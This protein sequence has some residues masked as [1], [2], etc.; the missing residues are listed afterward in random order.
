MFFLKKI[1]SFS[2]YTEIIFRR[3]YYFLKDVGIVSTK[4]RVVKKCDDKKLDFLVLKK[5]I[6]SLGIKEGDILIV[7][8]SY[9]QLSKFEVNP[10]GIINFLRELIGDEGTL[11]FPAFYIKKEDPDK[12]EI[13]IDLNKKVCSTGMLPAVFLRMKGVLRSPFPEN[14]LAAQGPRAEAMFEQ[15]LDTDLA[16]G[17]GSAWHF[18]A[19]NDA[20]ILLLGTE[21]AKTLTMVHV[22]EDVLDD[23]WP[24]MDWYEKKFFNLNYPDDTKQKVV[25]VRRQYWSRFMA[26]E[27]RTRW[28]KSNNLVSENI[29][30]GV[31]VAYVH[32]SK[33]L[34]ETL[35]NNMNSRKVY[36][37]R[38][39]TKYWRHRN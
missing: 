27:F 15:N 14:S 34:V 10:I 38:P 22:A 2:P 1:F 39:P 37:F 5:Y 33:S 21:A 20:K 12:Q 16:H 31:N 26:S 19:E 28:L 6:S 11:V 7:H 23:R 32:S 8:S 3:F 36:F 30:E 29:V 13:N 18:C 4:T 35:I 17:I 24:I 25:R 9:A